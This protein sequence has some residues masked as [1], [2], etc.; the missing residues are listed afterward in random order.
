MDNKKLNRGGVIP[1]FVENGE[2]KMMFM[3]PS[4]SEY[5]G[6]VFQIAKGKQEKDEDIKETAFRE[7]KEELGL[8]S[9]NIE[10]IDELGTFLGRTTIYIAKIKDINMFGEPT[11]ETDA[12]AW[13]TEDEFSKTGRVLHKPI[14]KSAQRKIEK[15]ENL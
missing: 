12:V 3:K 14:V 9:G 8:F 4:K 1:Y 5:G 11:D 15:L 10:R 13:L 2:I 6:S 7:A